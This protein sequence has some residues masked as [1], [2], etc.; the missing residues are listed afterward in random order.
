MPYNVLI[1]DDEDVIRDGL[2]SYEWE[3]LGF[4]ALC[5]ASDGQ[6]ALRLMERNP[7]H[8]AITDI[9]MPKLD[10]LD[11]SRIVREQYPRCKTVILTGYKDFEYAKAAITH[12]VSDYLMK[13]VSLNRI[14]EV[15]EKL[16]SELDSEEAERRQMVQFRKI[17]RET[18]P[19]AVCDFITGLLDGRISDRMEIREKLDLLELRLN[20]EYYAVIRM[21]LRKPG[22]RSS[23]RPEERFFRVSE[24]LETWFTENQVYGYGCPREGDMEYLISFN[25]SGSQNDDPREELSRIAEA[26]H[27]GIAGLFKEED[28]Q[29]TAGVGNYCTGILS[30]SLS[31]RQ[32]RKAL[33][34]CYFGGEGSVYYGCRCAGTPSGILEYP[35]E[36]ENRIIDALIEGNCREL[37]REKDTFIN[38]LSREGEQITPSIIQD[39]FLQFLNTL[40]NKLQQYG[41]T[42]EKVAGI[43]KPFL[44]LIESKKSLRELK[45]MTGE[46][47]EQACD[48]IDSMNREASGSAHK[49]IRE[50]V[51]FIK[52]NYRKK[53]TLDMVAEQ[54]YLNPSYLCVQFKKVTGKNFVDYIREWRTEKA[55]ELLRNHKLKVYEVG[56]AVGFQ[57]P[58]YFTDVFKEQTGLSPNKYRQKHNGL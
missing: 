42:L 37:H 1:V 51:D 8:V 16:K 35:Y 53:I 34:E 46:I 10:G 56:E 52:E 30:V 58:K 55:K 21:R 13:P 45:A 15:M 43:R 14:D 44:S 11:F 47:L 20:K 26:M 12:G 22:K 50:A 5:A 57:N 33:E 19:A 25:S 17:V 18:L 41:T 3:R 6:E 7:I 27:A 9:R 49:F 31:A 36:E 54:V 32:A 23:R 38:T 29:V 2:M 40:E 39:R 28:I 24:Y 4:S 48:T